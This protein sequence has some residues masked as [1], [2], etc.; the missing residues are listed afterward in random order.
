MTL[1]VLDSDHLVAIL[2]GKLDL[3]RHVAPSEQLAT[4]AV[5][6]AELAH[7]AHRS[8]R[9]A[10]NLTRVDT[11]LVALDILPFDEAAARVFGLI[12]A[13]LETQG[14]PLDA[15]DLQIASIALAHR[16]TLVTHNARH[17]GRVPQL[18]LDDWM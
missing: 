3:S 16:A 14:H 8:A 15:L 18:T 9:P 11:L 13:A 4:T 10:E 17:F 12:R 6:V 1:R 7:G 2:R 5:C